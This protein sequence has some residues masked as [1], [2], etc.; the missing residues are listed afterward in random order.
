MGPGLIFALL[1]QILD[2]V[3]YFVDPNSGVHTQ[4]IESFW[5]KMKRVT[6]SINGI[7][8]IRLPGLLSE[9]MFKDEFKSN[10]LSS[11][12]FLIAV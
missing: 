3:L 5:N 4:N 6:K 10:I 1:G 11:F 7:S 2:Q 8:K 12:M 9:L